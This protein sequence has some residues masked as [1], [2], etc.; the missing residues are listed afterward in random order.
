MV[1]YG[2]G[3]TDETITQLLSVS[4]PMVELMI[5]GGTSILRM[6]KCVYYFFFSSFH[7]RLQCQVQLLLTGSHVLTSFLF[8]T[9]VLF[10]F[11]FYFSCIVHSITASRRFK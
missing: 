5:T 11:R 6:I 7:E 9:F 2:C 1:I 10:L 4:L 3:Y 8:V